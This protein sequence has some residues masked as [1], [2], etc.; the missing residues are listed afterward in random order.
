[1]SDGALEITV[2][3]EEGQRNRVI[4]FYSLFFFSFIHKC[5]HCLGHFSLF[6][7][8]SLSPLFSPQF[9]AGPVLPLSLVLLEKRDKHNKEDKIFSLVELRI[10]IQKYS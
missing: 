10:A 8:P 9:K 7:L 1:M 2:E 3:Q 5:I 4:N 6:P